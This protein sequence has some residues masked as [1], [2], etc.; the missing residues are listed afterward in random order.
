MGERLAVAALVNTGEPGAPLNGATWLASARWPLGNKLRSD[1]EPGVK[2]RLDHVQAGS[3]IALTSHLR[4]PQPPV[5]AGDTALD[6]IIHVGHATAKALAVTTSRV[7]RLLRVSYAAQY[8]G[9]LVPDHG[10]DEQSPMAS[11]AGAAARGKQLYATNCARCHGLQGKGDGPAATYAADL[12]DDLRTE[13]NTEG[14]LFYEVW[15][16]RTKVGKG[17]TEDMPSFQGRLAK[18][19]VWALVEYLKVPRRP[20]R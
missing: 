18:D 4:A 11:M 14:V 10:R 9:W 1:F 5:L 17:T 16:G 13:L 6:G 15:N 8:P 12:T 2:T 7:A 3:A 19:E 20:R